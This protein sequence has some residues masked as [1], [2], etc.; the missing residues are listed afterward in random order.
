MFIWY[1]S[2][3]YKICARKY[4]RLFCVHIYIYLPNYSTLSQH[5]T[6]LCYLNRDDPTFY[7]VII[8]RLRHWS[9][10]LLLKQKLSTSLKTKSAATKF[11]RSEQPWL[12]PVGYGACWKGIA[13]CNRSQ[14]RFSSWK[15]RFAA[16]DDIPLK[17]INHA[18]K[19]FTKR[20][21]AC[22]RANADTLNT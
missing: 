14:R 4:T 15:P 2:N 3:K 19:D 5:L 10:H 16:M 20:L 7:N 21:K 22:V 11:H 1:H 8:L 17:P 9:L 12:S 13:N 18:I 6:K